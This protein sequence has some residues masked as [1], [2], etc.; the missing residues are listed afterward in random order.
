MSAAHIEICGFD[1]KTAE[2]IREKIRQIL[3]ENPYWKDAYFSIYER[4]S[5]IFEP[6]KF[7][8]FI[9]NFKDFKSLFAL[10]PKM[11]VPSIHFEM[12]CC[13]QR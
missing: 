8:R 10:V 7:V 1:T 2:K 6:G 13:D 9:G 3:C 5:S 12:S 11:G 4:R